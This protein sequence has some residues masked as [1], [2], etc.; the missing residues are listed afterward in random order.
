MTSDAY[1]NGRSGRDFGALYRKRGYKPF[2]M[3]RFEEYSL[4][5]ENRSFLVCD[6]VITFNDRRGRL[7]ALKPDVTLSIAKSCRDDGGTSKFYYDE[8][9][10][11]LDD[12]SG[13]FR[14]IMQSGLE[15]MGAIDL[16][17]ECEVLSLAV[18]S[19]ELIS[20]DC[21]L[22]VSHVGIP[23]AVIDDAGLD[24]DAA[25]KLL[26]AKNAHGLRAL[27]AESG[28]P[29]AKADALAELAQL[30]G[31]FA[32][33]LPRLRSLLPEAAQPALAELERVYS[34]MD[35]AGEADKLRLDFSLVSDMSYY[36]G[37]IFR[38][39][40]KGVTRAVI[41]GG[42]YDNLLKKLGKNAQAIGF[43]VYRDTL[44]DLD[45]APEY[46]ADVL[47]LCGDAAP[48]ETMRAVKAL[49]GAGKS[50]RVSRDGAGLRCREVK[51]LVK[52]AITDAE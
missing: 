39:F 12:A 10:Y 38:G 9:V 22:D 6:S 35:A 19:L 31:G 13:E 24:R 16:Y 48:E 32:E 8:N 11:R 41:S 37:I 15:C 27:C 46:D 18:K 28:V 7:M 29:A 40:V 1:K 25:L 43:A 20:G 49:N 5:A 14:E 33:L 26:A 50:V 2:R 30:Y 47:L 34:V 23:Q 21:V 51:K 3:N 44:A 4:Y 42:R 45:C 36:N 17:S 52:G